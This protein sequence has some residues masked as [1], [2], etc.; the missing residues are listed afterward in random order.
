[1]PYLFAGFYSDKMKLI[2]FSLLSVALLFLFSGCER[3]YLPAVYSSL[4]EG[5]IANPGYKTDKSIY[6]FSGDGGRATPF[7]SGESNYFF[8]GK[9]SRVTTSDHANVNI[10]A[11]FYG[12]M[13][14]VTGIYDYMTPPKDYNKTYNYFG[15]EPTLSLLLNFKFGNFKIGAGTRLGVIA[16]FGDFTDFRKD[17]MSKQ[18]ASGSSKTVGLEISGFPYFAYEFPDCTSLSL[19]LNM[20]LPGGVAPSIVYNGKYASYWCAIGSANLGENDGLVLQMGA[21]LNLNVFKF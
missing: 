17:V 15:F 7:N 12:G 16:E 10:G 5:M 19:Q 13:Y 18:L 11:G 20:G 4:P 21:A 8:R 3:I 6:Y 1:V 9:I 2:K 14:K